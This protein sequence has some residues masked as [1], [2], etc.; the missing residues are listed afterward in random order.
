MNQI[1]KYCEACGCDPC[2]CGWGNHINN[3]L[4]CE[5][6]GMEYQYCECHWGDRIT[7]DKKCQK[8][9]T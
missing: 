5:R 8:Y 2:D 4:K 9:G 1:N 3:Q 6:C 7:G